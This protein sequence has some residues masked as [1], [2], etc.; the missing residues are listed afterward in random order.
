LRRT[1]TH[2]GV[3]PVPGIRR[4]RRSTVLE[5]GNPAPTVH[6]ETR[7]DREATPEDLQD[8]LDTWEIDPDGVNS[9]I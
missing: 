4:S 1:N 7:E 2:L 3:T 6:M 8:R 9:R 5:Q